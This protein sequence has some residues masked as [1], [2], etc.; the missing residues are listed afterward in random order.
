MGLSIKLAA[1]AKR[2]WA[3]LGTDRR[4]VSAVEFALIAPVMIVILFG[5]IEI[6][7]LMTVDRKVTR[8]TSAIADLVAQDD[9]ITADEMID[10]FTATS[11]IMQPYDANGMQMRVSSVVMANDGSVAVDWSEAQSM[12]ARAPGSAVSVPAGIL[13]PN[14]SIVMAEVRYN[15]S[16]NL[17]TFLSTPILLKETFYLRPRRALKVTGP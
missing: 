11:T 10:I 9:I 1:Q 4:G 15:Y 14:S 16:S 5:V 3:R 12:S 17:G 7:M 2:F 13:Q 6:S 8:A